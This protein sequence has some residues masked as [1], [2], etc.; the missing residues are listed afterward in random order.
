MKYRFLCA[1]IAHNCVIFRKVLLSHNKTKV[2]KT[3]PAISLH[4][5][6]P[7]VAGAPQGAF[8][9]IPEISQTIFP[10]IIKKRD[11]IAFIYKNRASPRVH[12]FAWGGS[13]F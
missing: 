13:V 7:C 9:D 12:R 6:L 3:E 1:D 2:C 8:V 4:A 10:C 5:C 11:K